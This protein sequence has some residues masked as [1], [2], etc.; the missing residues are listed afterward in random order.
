M[1]KGACSG[2]EKGRD[3]EAHAHEE[4]EPQGH[5][6]EDPFG[7]A[8]GQPQPQPGPGEE[9]R[10]A[11]RRQQ[12]QGTVEETPQEEEQRRDDV[13]AEKIGGQSGS[14][15]LLPHLLVRQKKDDRRPAHGE[16]AVE[17]AAEKADGKKRP[18]S[19][20]KGTTKAEGKGQG[21]SRHE[22][23]GD[24]AKKRGRQK[25]KGRHP[26][27][28]ARDASQEEAQ[29]RRPRGVTSALAEEKAVHGQTEE[30]QEGN[31][32]VA[33]KEG[34]QKGNGEKGEAE[35]R[36]ALEKAAEKDGTD[37]VQDLQDGTSPFSPAA[38]GFFPAATI[39]AAEPTGPCVLI[40][41][42]GLA[43]G[44]PPFSCRRRRSTEKASPSSGFRYFSKDFDKARQRS[45]CLLQ[46]S[47]KVHPTL[48]EAIDVKK[49]LSALLILAFC[50][51]SLPV[52]GQAATTIKI[53]HVLNTDHS[54]NTCLLGLAEDV[55][56][57]T[58]GR[59][60]IQVYPSS[61]LGNEKDLI[62]GLTLQTVDGGLIGGGSFQ[63][64]EPKLG[65][66]ALPYAWP[67]H[68]AAYRAL[69]GELGDRLLK[70]LADKGVVGLSWWENGFR[71]L[72]NSK[73]P[74]VVPADLQGM[75]IRV[76]P[77]KMRLDTFETLGASPMPINFG[78]LYTALQ[79]GVVDGQE[80]PFAIIYS[81]AF[82][83]VQKYLSLSGHI[84]G[85]AL[86]CVN[87]SVWA[88]LSP[89]DQATVRE[90]AAKWRDEQRRQTIAQEEE[91][92][93]KLKE[94]GMEINEVDKGAFQAAVQEV[95][96]RYEDVFGA[97]LLDLV[98]KYGH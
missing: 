64:I 62:E 76:T 14:E 41:T 42:P 69:D 50:I 34:K 98:R 82:Y 61:Q 88:K 11:R 2:R 1:K 9:G 46:C 56:N 45:H 57:A 32:D 94:K 71:H 12:E 66:E 68:E 70:L 24:E 44:T 83:E 89:Q 13:E 28:K 48:L 95:W 39:R 74:I 77:D 63:S 49:S 10:Q 54:W 22:E 53:G 40:V 21:R 37:R 19:G 91:F 25:G 75:K 67:T 92:L 55:K 87:P 78:E 81:S 29:D 58:E 51:F 60:L 3:D 26:Q 93:A 47:V 20:R 43:G 36:A 17:D 35:S 8:A 4:K 97:D 80:N 31:D 16:A 33:R 7:K 59:V 86:L 72:T 96:G 6:A 15:G 90:L 27:G 18:P 79:Q 38:F 23:T 65:I 85:S 84:W 52:A 30:D 5:G 73:K